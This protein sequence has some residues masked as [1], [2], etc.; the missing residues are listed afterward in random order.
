MSNSS[1]EKRRHP[2]INVHV[3]IRTTDPTKKPDEQFTNLSETGAFI[4]TDRPYPL[5]TVIG[6]ELSSNAAG[7]EAMFLKGRVVRIIKTSEYTSAGMGVEF[8]QIPPRELSRLRKLVWGSGN[9][10]ATVLLA[11]EDSKLDSMICAVLA[12]K[13]H[14]VNKARGLR[15][16][17]SA[18]REGIADI[19]IFDVSSK[20][21]DFR[22]LKSAS[23]GLPLVVVCD[24]LTPDLR[25]RAA[26]QGLFELLEKPVAANELLSAIDRE[27]QARSLRRQPTPTDATPTKDEISLVARSKS[28]QQVVKQLMGLA[29]VPHP[30]LITGETGVGKEVVARALHAIG[31][32]R[33]RRFEVADCTLMDKNLMASMLFGHEK[34]AYTGADSRYDGHVK[35]AGDGIL[36]LDE[37]GELSMEGQ[38][39]LLRLL[40][41][42]T[43]RRLGGNEDLYCKARI[44]AATNRDLRTMV[45]RGEFREDLLYRLQVHT[46]YVAPLRERP[47]DLI[48]LTYHLLDELNKECSTEFTGLSPEAMRQ[49]NT[50]QWTGNVREL[51]NAL[52]A[53]ILGVDGDVI[54]SLKIADDPKLSN[55]IGPKSLEDFITADYSWDDFVKLSKNAERQYLLKLLKRFDGVIN[56]AA[57]FCG[58]SRQNL[59]KKLIEHKIKTPAAKT[60]KPRPRKKKTK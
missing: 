28:M 59:S 40:E 9:Y 41:S 50:H 53:S 34:G 37:I 4:Q 8:F 14:R 56:Q 49:L 57:K 25:A 5:G 58:L 12:E 33:D 17:T 30:V 1:V 29:Q 55:G 2:R 47:E 10:S 26:S 24:K 46:V 43:Y 21:V 16:L 36:F 54:P 52:A 7:S 42:G 48:P 6:I 18:S 20:K 3:C 13:R 44:L 60:T 51:R 45:Q 15:D 35:Q 11:T 38:A 22:V 19:A 23:M 27:L 31:Q 39:K 32:R